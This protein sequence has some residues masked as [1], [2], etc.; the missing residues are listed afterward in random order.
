V[1]WLRHAHRSAQFYKGR[2]TGD[3]YFDLKDGDL[4]Y[5]YGRSLLTDYLF[6]GDPELLDAIERIAGAGER[7]DPVYELDDNFWTERHQTY[8]LLAALSDRKS[9]RLNS[10][11]VKSSYAVFCL[12]KE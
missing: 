4:K 9:T 2:I 6:T 5:A 7:W 8:A 1:K 11:H 12:K 3:G 10:S